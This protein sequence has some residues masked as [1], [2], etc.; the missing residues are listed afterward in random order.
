MKFKSLVSLH[1]NYLSLLDFILM[2]RSIVL[3]INMYKCVCVISTIHCSI[4][5]FV[6]F[7]PTILYICIAECF[8]ILSHGFR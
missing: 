6:Y 4:V 3:F 2:Y 1:L 5:Q 8:Q 7:T